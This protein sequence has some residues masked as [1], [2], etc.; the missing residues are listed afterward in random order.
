MS[1]TKGM[2][3]QRM[4]GLMAEIY[5]VEGVTFDMVLC[6]GACVLV[7]LSAFF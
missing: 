4:V 7:C 1:V 6:I 5:G 3:T 2:S